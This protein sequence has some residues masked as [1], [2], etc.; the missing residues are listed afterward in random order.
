MKQKKFKLTLCLLL[1]GFLSFAQK[2]EFASK[3]NAQVKIQAAAQISLENWNLYMRNDLDSLKLDGLHIYRLG[4]K[5]GNPFAIHVGKR[6]LGSYLI[7]T[8]NQEKGIEYLKA[9]NFYFAKKEN[10][11]LQ[12]ETLN[13]IGN[14]YLYFSKP[15]VAEKYYL[16]SLKCGKKSPDPT[17]AFL[18]EV[19]LAQAYID[20]GNTTKATAIL[21]HYKNQAKKMKKLE[22]VSNAYALLGAIQSGKG[23]FSLSKELFRKSAYYG[24]ASNAIAQIAHAYTNMAIV[25]FQEGN[26]KEALNYFNKSLEIRLKTK[27][28][29]SISESYF[30]L[31]EYY[32]GIGDVQTA[33]LYYEKCKAY[34]EEN[35]LLKEEMEVLLSLINIDKMAKNFEIAVQKMEGYIALQKK[36][37]SE[38]SELNTRDRDIIEIV[39]SLEREEYDK[40]EAQKLEESIAAQIFQKYVLYAIF[41]L[42]AIAL[43][44]LAFYRKKII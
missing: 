15:H 41:S 5:G 17:S 7:R 27:N 16:K 21:N 6:S 28:V 3:S 23:K 13:E 43:V 32:S 26:Q 39:E 31:G 12:T 22:S 14:G 35:N 42:C 8:G 33:A 9:A 34:C 25:Y 30:N 37:Y 19:N 4:V 2:G 1:F 36:Y 38:V 44:F 29:R 18:A 24:F 11:I 20:M 10:Y 40:K